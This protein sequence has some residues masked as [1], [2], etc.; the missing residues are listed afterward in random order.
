LNNLVVERFSFPSDPDIFQR[1]KQQE[2]STCFV[3]PS[4]NEYCFEKPRGDED[5]RFS[6]PIGSNGISGEMHFE[7][8]NNADGYWTMSSIIHIPN[9]MVTITFSD[10][11]DR[12]PDETLANWH[13]TEKFEF[14][15]T[16]E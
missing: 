1:I 7:P 9:D 2:D 4:D 16:L 12:Y 10:N 5:S 6:Y 3:T 11:S 15:Q 14:T 8:V 13:I